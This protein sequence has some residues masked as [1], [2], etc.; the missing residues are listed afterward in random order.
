MLNVQM[1]T[2]SIST[3]SSRSRWSVK[4]RSGGRPQARAASW[5]RS[6]TMSATPTI[7]TQGICWKYLTWTWA[8][9][10]APMMPILTV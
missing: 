9:R 6:A 5:A 10:P 8:M 3:R 2:A 7:S 4:A 1:L